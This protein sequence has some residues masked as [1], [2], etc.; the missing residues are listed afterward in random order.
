MHKVRLWVGYES[1]NYGTGERDL[2]ITNGWVANGQLWCEKLNDGEHTAFPIDQILLLKG[3]IMNSAELVIEVDYRPS[4]CLWRFQKL[5]R[6]I[7]IKDES[8]NYHWN[9]R[10]LSGAPEWVTRKKY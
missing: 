3:Y 4:F 10:S 5:Q 9:A 7:G 6:F 8:G 1:I 2:T